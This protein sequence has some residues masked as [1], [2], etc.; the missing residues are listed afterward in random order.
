M[1]FC[2]GTSVGAESIA[3]TMSWGEIAVIVDRI[4]LDV[5]A[6]GLPDVIVGIM[7][8]GM[9]PAILLAHGL[10][11]RDVRALDVTHTVN[12]D[13]NAPK[14]NIP[15][16]R[17]LSSMGDINGRDVLLVDD[18]A[19]TCETLESGAKLVSDRGARRVRTAVVVVNPKNMPPGKSNEVGKL[20][21]YIGWRSQGWVIFPWEKK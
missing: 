21:T 8:G 3:A 15:V 6:D 5:T 10:A 19:G 1:Y 16:T 11:C 2:G 9:I 12:D 20:L 17:N 14:T 4:G 13:V 18:I 7:R